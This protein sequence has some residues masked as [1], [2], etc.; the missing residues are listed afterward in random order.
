MNCPSISGQFSHHAFLVIPEL[1]YREELY[2]KGG[3]FSVT[4]KILVHDFL[5]KY[6]SIGANKWDAE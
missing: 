4:S 3:L 5:R 2:R 6:P 1:M